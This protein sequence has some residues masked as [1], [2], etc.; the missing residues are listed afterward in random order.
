MIDEPTS[1]IGAAGNEPEPQGR[2]FSTVVST[3]GRLMRYFPDPDGGLTI[4]VEGTR[5]PLRFDP[6][7]TLALTAAIRSLQVTS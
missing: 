6:F 7:Q 4:L 1:L 3:D 5:T 2:A